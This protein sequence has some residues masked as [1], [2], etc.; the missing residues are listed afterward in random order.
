SGGCFSSGGCPAAFGASATEPSTTFSAGGRETDG[1]TASSATAWVSALEPGAFAPTGAALVP[2][3]GFASDEAFD[4]DT[5][6]ASDGVLDFAIDFGCVTFFACGTAAVAG[7]VFAVSVFTG[8]TP[9]LPSAGLLFVR[10]PSASLFPSFAA[11]AA[12]GFAWA[13]G[14]AA[15]AF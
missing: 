3:A 13:G 12:V 8:G 6:L 5:G 9:A 14:A 1:R 7:F 4:P 11:R 10:L 15:F 2:A